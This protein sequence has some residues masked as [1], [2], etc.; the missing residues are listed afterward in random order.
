MISKIVE[1]P[2]ETIFLSCVR[3]E[4]AFPQFWNKW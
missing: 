4:Q 2:G 3:E 1:F